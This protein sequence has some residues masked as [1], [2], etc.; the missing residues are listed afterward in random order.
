[1]EEHDGDRFKTEVEIWPFQ[2]CTMT[3]IQYNDYL[4]L[5]V[6]F[7]LTIIVT[8]SCGVGYGADIAF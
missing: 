5:S 1:V 2:A 4:S 6:A 7:L 3:N 8:F